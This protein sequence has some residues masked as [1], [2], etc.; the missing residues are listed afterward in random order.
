MS[1]SKLIALVL[2]VPL[3]AAAASQ[4]T[5]NGESYQCSGNVVVANGRVTC[6]GTDLTTGTKD[7]APCGKGIEMIAHTNPDGSKGGR[8]A[9][10]VQ[11]RSPATISISADSVICG[12][13][14]LEG[15]VSVASSRLNGPG[16]INGDGSKG[17]EIRGSVLNGRIT[18]RGNGILIDRSVV[19]GELAIRDSARIVGGVFNGRTELSGSSR[20]TMSV[21]NGDV[22]LPDNARLDGAV[23]R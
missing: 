10:H 18:A 5:V 11:L 4:I 3:L 16:T 19:N 2:L 17:V 20:I 7:E 23:V 21:V 8:Y 22:E 12:R 9:R 15:K 1:S 14:T 6:N 13:C